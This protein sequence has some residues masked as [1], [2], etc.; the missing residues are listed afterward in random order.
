MKHAFQTPA[1]K[2]AYDA[3]DEGPRAALL[4]LRDLI[5]DTADAL[6][7]G[8][9]EESLK[10]GQPS[11]TTAGSRAATPIRL[12][13]TKTGDVG[14]F[15]HCQST[16]MSDFRAL[17]PTDMRFDGNRGLLLEPNDTLPLDDI[18][19]LIRAALTYRL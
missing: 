17:A 3:F 7:V 19:P 8:A 13:V 9:I 18:T 2:S 1:I 15:T 11:Y 10:W 5:F 16:V 12:G 6:P 14:M 4:A